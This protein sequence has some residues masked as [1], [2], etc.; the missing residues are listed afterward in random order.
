[1]RSPTRNIVIVGGGF[2]GTV[3]AANLLRRPPRQQTRIVLVERRA[4][5]GRGVAYQSGP[6]QY[7]L[8]V[9]AGRMSADSR[10]PTQFVRFA[11]RRRSNVTAGD[12]L[13]RQLYGDYLQDLLKTAEQAAPNHIHLDAVRGQARAIHRIEHADSFLVD[14]SG[15]GNFAAD[16]VVLA[17]GDPAPVCPGFARNVEGHPNF[18]CDPYRE[19]AL[20]AHARTMVV[21]GTGL[22]A[23]DTIV[24]AATLSPGIT[25]HAISRHGLLP[26]VQGGGAFNPT[27]LDIPSTM[28]VAPPTARRLLREFRLL[29]KVVER[30]GGDWRDAMTIGRHA[31]P[32]LWQQL[33]LVERRRFLRHARTYW[34]VHRHRLPPAIAARLAALREANRLYIHAGRILGIDSEGE[35]L[36]VRWRP[37]GTADTARQS[38]DR[39]A[40]CMGADQ[41][42]EHCGE[43]LLKGLL[44]SGLAM[45]DPLGVGLRTDRHGALLCRTGR[46]CG[47]LFYLGPMLRAQHWEATAVGEL[48]VHAEQLAQSLA[49]EREDVCVAP[50]QPVVS[51][52][53]A[54]GN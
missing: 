33:P 27:D 10:D 35:S 49:F 2:C 40:N 23:A 45:A 21:I 50:S 20:R 7:L 47:R 19:G 15:H 53:L 37:R 42:L 34:D 18:A 51:K 24:T 32:R 43:P 36:R 41:R 29:A 9:P 6:G 28:E 44:G 14:V 30:R 22:T 54:T 31:A 52:I 11:Q 17:C 39:V 3:L 16:D 48:R 8:N 38:V 4:E 5:L 13:P 12:F 25:I 1:M 46:A 26:A